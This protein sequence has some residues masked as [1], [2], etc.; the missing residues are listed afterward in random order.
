VIAMNEL[1]V[2]RTPEELLNSSEHF[3][4]DVTAQ[5][6]PIISLKL[7]ALIKQLV[8]VAYLM[9]QEDGYRWTKQQTIT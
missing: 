1:Q 6:D 5:F 9:G 3:M 7:T 2:Q 8:N 4:L